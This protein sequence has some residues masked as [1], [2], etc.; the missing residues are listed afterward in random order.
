MGQH[1]ITVTCVLDEPDPPVVITNCV[2]PLS[3]AQRKLP[4]ELTTIV[5]KLTRMYGAYCVVQIAFC[6][7][8]NEFEYL[9]CVLTATFMYS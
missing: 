9:Q 6:N 5:E 8:E 4:K 2:V 3:A 7:P 1:I